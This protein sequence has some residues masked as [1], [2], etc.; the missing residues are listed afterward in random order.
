[1][2]RGPIV[3]ML[4]RIEALAQEIDANVPTD[5]PGLIDFR[6]DLAG[7]LN[8]TVCATYENCVK[9]IIHDYAG[10]QSQLFRVYAQNQY[11]RINS[12]IDVSDLY[13]YAKTFHP[14]IH[15]TFKERI[16]S[17]NAYYL[18]RT[19]SDIVVSYG[20]LLSWRHS[21][22]HTGIRVTTVEEVIRHHRLAKRVIIAFA[23]AFS[24]FP[25]PSPI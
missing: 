14:D 12:R 22:A 21:F 4:S 11:D 1:M 7:L 23:D 8:V 15:R 3:E 18:R 10:R 24:D 16:A 9:A 5:Q 17:T 6:A 19:L 2:N 20:Q 13:R 25:P